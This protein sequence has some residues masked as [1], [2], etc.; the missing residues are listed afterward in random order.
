[1][2]SRP[3]FFWWTLLILWPALAY[4]NQSLITP[5]G[6][7]PWWAG[8]GAAMAVLV[9]HYSTGQNF[10]CRAVLGALLLVW[11]L[12]NGVVAMLD[13]ASSLSLALGSDR[14][15]LVRQSLGAWLWAF[16]MVGWLR[17][18]SWRFPAGAALEL[19][20][21]GGV[22][23]IALEAHRDGY[24]NRPFQMVDPLWLRGLDPSALFIAVGSLALVAVC[25]LA[26]NRPGN[27][28]PWWDLP[29]LLLLLMVLYLA[30]PANQVKQLFEKFG[31]GKPGGEENRLTPEGGLKTPGPASPNSGGTPDPNKK[32][33][34]DEPSFADTSKP[35]PVPVAVVVF[36]DDY[37]PLSGAYYFRQT[38][39]SQ[40][41]GI[42]LVHSNDDRFDRDNALGFPTRFHDQDAQP[43][44]LGM[45]VPSLSKF[46]F[47]PLKTRVALLDQHPRPF[48]LVNP[49]HYWAVSN[50]DPDRFQKAYEVESMV[51]GGDYRALIPNKAGDQ[52]WAADEWSHY[53][54]GPADPRY[55][56]L[57]DSIL[58]KVP[59]AGRDSALIRAVYIKQ[60]LDDNCTYSL[61]SPSANAAD[62]VSDFLF[63]QRIGYCVFTSH[64]ACYL[65]RAAGIPARISDGYM[66]DAKQRGGGSSLLIRSSDA[67]SWPE[68]YL[69]DVGWMD[70]DISPKKNLEPEKEQVDNNLQ[71]MMGDMAR[72]DKKDRRPEENRPTIDL[73]QL[74]LWFL[75]TLLT[76]LLSA[77]LLGWLAM[78]LWKLWRRRAPFW[79]TGREQARLAYLCVLDILSEQGV[80]RRPD[81]SCEE[82]ARRMSEEMPGLLALV[83]VHLRA[84]LGPPQAQLE[85]EV[86]P[87]LKECLSQL[88]RRKVAGWRGYL[89]WLDPTSPL[90]VR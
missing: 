60:W 61:K 46:L 63:G 55:K 13:G 50:P 70:L 5:L 23:V 74:T 8:V 78:L 79:S 69:Q 32:P 31:M 58:A 25:V 36:Q 68:I 2:K 28:R 4:W 26:S 29:L 76:G 44:E 56:E 45:R 12:G 20:A 1:M 38:S 47:Q 15:V 18:L 51:L 39:E 16:C 11:L 86:M 34:P 37:E 35:K 9:W 54:A 80:R 27:R 84:R 83:R 30:V 14:W 62:P 64:S 73:H 57:A 90:R 82:F 17:A 67:H 59:E 53:L 77:L 88:R 71:Q 48:G 42:K 19:A 66:V 72:K 40:F 89:G 10:R 41:N 7:I 87:L 52:D 81:E 22:F 75:R 3:R 43:E 65:F 21:A 49:L 33:N 85:R 24:I 6:G